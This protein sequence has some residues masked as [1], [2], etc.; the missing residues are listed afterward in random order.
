MFSAWVA[1]TEAYNVAVLVREKAKADAEMAEISTMRVLQG[2]ARHTSCSAL[3]PG[4]CPSCGSQEF[5]MWRGVS[6][7]AYCRS[8]ATAAPRP[9]PESHRTSLASKIASAQIEMLRCKRDIDDSYA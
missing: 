5:R 2:A 7:C 3:H 6:V 1:A 8:T 4:D 9:M